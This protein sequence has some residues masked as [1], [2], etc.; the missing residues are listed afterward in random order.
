MIDGMEL[1][2]DLS[3]RAVLSTADLVYPNSRHASP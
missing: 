1:N 2:A 3:Q